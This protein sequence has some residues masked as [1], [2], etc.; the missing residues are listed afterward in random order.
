MF[1]PWNTLPDSSAGTGAPSRFQSPD[2]DD[3]SGHGNPGG[4]PKAKM[5]KNVLTCG[6]N[7]LTCSCCS[8]QERSV[9]QRKI[10]GKCHQRRFNWQT[11]NA[12]SCLSFPNCINDPEA[13]EQ[14]A[15]AALSTLGVSGPAGCCHS[16]PL[17][18]EPRKNLPPALLT[19]GVLCC[20]CPG[21]SVL[22][23]LQTEL[24]ET[25]TLGNPQFRW[26]QR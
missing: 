6:K 19:P 10:G 11:P 20:P 18:P 15:Q 3:P 5:G 21:C 7:V 22:R 16:C 8:R 12:D 9:G 17:P 25:S 4:L 23:A 24:L 14:E 26:G 1:P 2:W 13:A